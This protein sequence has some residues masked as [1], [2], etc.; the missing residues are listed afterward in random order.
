MTVVSV[1][2]EI[3]AS[4]ESVWQLMGGFDA[5]P[6]WLPMILRSVSQEG[7][8]ARALTT[9]EGDTIVERLETFDN[10]LR[11]YSY[12]I[13]QASLPVADYYSTLSVHATD[14]NTISRVEWCC[15]F[16]P[17]NIS[18]AQAVALFAG[19]Y[20]DGLNALKNNFLA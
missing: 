17:V 9:T 20:E 5:L 15:R 10:Q 1:S 4:P 8:R 12:T 6:D 7:G 19:I 2:K 14:D 11:S 18:D 16:T 3:T 13:V